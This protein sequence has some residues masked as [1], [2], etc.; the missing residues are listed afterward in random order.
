MNA[1]TDYFFY[2]LDRLY[3]SECIMVNKNDRHVTPSW[4]KT[5]NYIP[6]LNSPDC[7][8]NPNCF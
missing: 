3:Y 7:P 6:Y 2:Q 4:P 8:D 5:F 1:I